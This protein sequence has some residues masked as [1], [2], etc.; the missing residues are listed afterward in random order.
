M[1]LKVKLL[2]SLFCCSSLIN[3]HFANIES[4]VCTVNTNRLL[5]NQI[6]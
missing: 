2:V 6:L 3:L 4:V 5:V 1:E